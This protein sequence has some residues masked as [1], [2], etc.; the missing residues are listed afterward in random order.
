M[1]K[2]L[3]ILVVLGLAQPLNAGRCGS[4][5]AAIAGALGGL[6][7]G[8]M[9]GSA[10]AS[11]TNKQA[12]HAERK[13]DK[14]EQKA[15]RAQDKAEQLRIEQDQQRINQLERELERREVERKIAEVHHKHGG[16][17]NM[18]MILLILIG[19][20]TVAVIGLSIMVLRRKP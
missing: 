2:H 13:A 4:G 17:D 11:G 20:L 14:A 6:A 9:I 1:K 8:T 7:V 18:M 10:T 15:M 12:A 3:L 16:H 5:G 19:F